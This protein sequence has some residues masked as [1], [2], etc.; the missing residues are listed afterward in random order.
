MEAHMICSTQ[1]FQIQECPD[2][3]IDACI[4]D[5]GRNL[6]FVSLWGRDTALQEFLARLTLGSAENGLTQFHILQD[7]RSLP[8]FPNADQL[9][10]RTTRQYRS[11]LFGSLVHLWLFDK[12]C[13]QPDHAAHFAYALL[14]RDAE[15]AASLWP[16]I[17]ETCPLPLLP[18]WQTP[19]LEVLTELQMLTPLPGAIGSISG[20][21]LN[22]QLAPLEQ[23]LG[24]LIRQGQLTTT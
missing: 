19:V 14:K 15:V 23:A 8:V 20:W 5:E 13:A 21:E 2:L 9:E 4:C 7:G 10:K 1:L 16:L 17:I 22:L 12:R 6:V 3:Y 18:H 11:K 24:D